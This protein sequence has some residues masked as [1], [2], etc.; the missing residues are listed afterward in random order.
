MKICV[1]G[2]GSW[3]T[4]NAL[5]LAENGHD[6]KIWCREPEVSKSINE[7]NENMFLP[8]V[9]VNVK[10]DT[11]LEIIKDSDIVVFAIPSQYAREMAKKISSY[12]GDA[13]I[14]SLTKGFEQGSLKRISQVLK[15]ELNNKIVV[16][17]GPNHAEEIVQKIPAATTIASDD[18]D[19]LEIVKKAYELPYFKVY[20]V[21]DLVGVEVGGAMKNITA[22]AVGVCEELGLGDNA[23]AS[24]ITLGLSE[25]INVGKKLGGKL[26]TFTGLAGVG[27]LVATCTSRHSRNRKVGNLMARGMNFE[28]IKAE[29]KGMVA[30]GMTAVRN[31]YE[32]T[33]DLPLTTQMYKVLYEDKSLEEAKDDLLK[34]I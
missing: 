34:L 3:G 25:M 28:Q 27:D 5:M 23:K 30:E 6:V 10:A 24:I 8:G 14:V 19:C 9:K 29:M 12:V 17:S 7:E 13:I 11:S 31:V 26:S 33:K 16:L 15:E 32:F 4:T 1:V 2:A 22:I 20:I 21:N 18:T